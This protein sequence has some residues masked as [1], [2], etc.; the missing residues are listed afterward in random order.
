MS[1]SS[2]EDYVIAY[3]GTSHDWAEEIRRNGFELDRKQNGATFEL[4]E[5]TGRSDPKSKKYH[6]LTTSL[7]EAA[8][9]AK[10]HKNPE[11][12]RVIC[13][14]KWL[15]Q[16]PQAG[17]DSAFRTTINIK[18]RC[19]LPTEI[20]SLDKTKVTKIKD[21]IFEKKQT[22]AEFHQK[23]KEAVKST[24][25]DKEVIRKELSAVQMVEKQGQQDLD[26]I[27]KGGFKLTDLRE[28]MIFSF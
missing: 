12:L 4:F 11:I 13:K 18:R 15:E 26:A 25:Y 1:I 2:K 14:R 3:H 22:P 23:L 5:K 27:L 8:Q 10:I 16:D 9:Y 24:A 17:S 7:K 21:I 6:Y 28:G 19:V 20:S